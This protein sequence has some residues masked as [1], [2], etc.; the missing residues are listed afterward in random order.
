MDKLEGK[1]RVNHPLFESVVFPDEVEAVNAAE[2]L[3]SF[4]IKNSDR[5][6]VRVDVLRYATDEGSDGVQPIWWWCKTVEAEL[7]IRCGEEE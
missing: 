5:T 7:S 4:L 3:C 1:Y 2:R 6:E